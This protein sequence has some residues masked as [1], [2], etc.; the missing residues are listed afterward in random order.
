MHRSFEQEQRPRTPDANVPDRAGVYS[1]VGA[2]T[3]PAPFTDAFISGSFGV[4]PPTVT[5]STRGLREPLFASEGIGSPRSEAEEQRTAQLEAPL[6]EGEEEE[7]L[8]GSKETAALKAKLKMRL[9]EIE[10]EQLLEE[11]RQYEEEEQKRNAGDG[12]QKR[13]RYSSGA[14]SQDEGEE[15]SV[16]M[17]DEEDERELEALE[18]VESQR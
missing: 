16:G 2:E 17:L 3:L 9:Q 14:Q 18:E 15:S 8:T 1:T 7:V 13:H 12:R 5:G 10:T 6:S 4:Q 11:M